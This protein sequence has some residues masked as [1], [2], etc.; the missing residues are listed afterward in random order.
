MKRKIGLSNT[1]IKKAFNFSIYKTSK[2]LFGIYLIQSYWTNEDTWKRILFLS[3]VFLFFELI[4]LILYDKTKKDWLGIE[5]LKEKIHNPDL[6]LKPNK[7]A[8]KIAMW[9]KPK[10]W[11][12]KII[13]FFLIML[14]DTFVPVIYFRKGYRTYDGFQ[15]NFLLFFL[16]VFVIIF[17]NSI[18]FYEVNFLFFLLNICLAY[19]LFI[20]CDLIP[21]WIIS[22]IKLKIILLKIGQLI[23]PSYFFVSSIFLFL[24]HRLSSASLF[25]ASLKVSNFS[26][27]FNTTGRRILV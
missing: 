6:V 10:F 16:F 14:I 4:V 13:L 17:G 24:G 12:E 19:A 22:Q 11:Y 26:L 23:Q 3:V 21:L 18:F 2:H 20:I 25:L 7:V 27:Y 15:N 9:I 1:L 8:D 5:G